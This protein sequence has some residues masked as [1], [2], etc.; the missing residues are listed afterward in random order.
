MIMVH[1][2]SSC[3]FCNDP[4]E[5]RDHLFFVCKFSE[6]VWKGLT[7]KLLATRYTNQWDQIIQLVIDQNRDKTELYIVRYVF[8][9]T[10]YAIW[11]ERN[12]RRHG[13]SPLS[14]SQLIQMV[15]KNVRNRLSSIR[16]RAHT[17]G[18]VLWFATR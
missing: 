13:E 5:S 10:L 17:G 8:Q 15:D 18:L 16:A 14:P 4:I 3:V 9:A 7:Q 6:E 2:P 11:R 12:Q 1:H